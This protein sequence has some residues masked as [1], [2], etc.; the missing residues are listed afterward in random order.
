[1]VVFLPLSSVPLFIKPPRPKIRDGQ[2]KKKITIWH[3]GKQTI[4]EVIKKTLDY[5]VELGYRITPRKGTVS[6]SLA[7][8]Q[9]K[10]Q[11]EM[12]YTLDSSVVRQA[13]IPI[14]PPG[15]VTGW[16]CATIERALEWDGG[17]LVLK[18]G[19]ATVRWD[20]NGPNPTSPHVDLNTVLKV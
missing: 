12:D 7:G 10:V 6:T 3:P 14:A 15:R 16:L 1:M 4:K 19:S 2:E 8:N 9:L 18:D 20:P 17:K 13:S 11:L 5:E